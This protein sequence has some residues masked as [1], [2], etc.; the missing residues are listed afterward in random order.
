M[1]S[2]VLDL[3][4]VDGSGSP[5]STKFSVSFHGYGGSAV[6]EMPEIEMPEIEMPEIEVPD[7]GPEISR[8]AGD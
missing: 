8:Y 5:V 1:R 3:S 2:G 4:H 6:I 7:E